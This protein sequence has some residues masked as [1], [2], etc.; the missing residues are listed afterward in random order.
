MKTDVIQYDSEKVCKKFA[1]ICKNID[2]NCEEK[3][4]LFKRLTLYLYA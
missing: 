4:T 2:K 3:V 1:A